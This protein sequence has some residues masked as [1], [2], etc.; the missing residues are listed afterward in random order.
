MR[1]EV[2]VLICGG[3]GCGLA[4]AVMLADLGVDYLL[5]ER[6]PTTAVM[7][8]AHILNVR[9]MEILGQ[10]GLAEEVYRTGAPQERNSTCR[11]YT[12]LGGEEPWD[13]RELFAVDAWGGRSLRPH[14]RRLSAYRHGNV[15]QIL[16]EPLLRREAEARPL[17]EVLFNHELTGFEQDDDGVTAEI[18]DRESGETHSVH[19]GYLI[20][21]DGGKTVGSRLGIEMAGPEPFVE[22]VSVYFRADLSPYLD[23]DDSLIRLFLRP[24]TEGG[25]I[26]TGCVGHGPTKWDRHCEE[27]SVS[28]TLTPEQ[29]QSEYDE[30]DAADAVRERLNLPDL[31]LEV[32]RTS[33]WKIEAVVA[34]RYRAGRVFLAGDA[35]HR[36][37]PMGGLGL[38]TG[39]QDA[40]NLTAKLAAVVH[41]QARPALLESYE[42]ERRPVGRRNVEFSTFAF[43]NHLGVSAGF[44]TMPGAPPSHNRAALEALFSDTADGATRRARLEGYFQTLRMEFQCA[45]I[46]LGFEYS[47]SPAVVPDGSD[48]PRRDPTG[49]EYVPVARPGHRLPHAWLERF[50]RALSTHHLQR[51]GWWL[52]LAGD[53]GGDWCDA[54][55]GLAAELGLDLAAERIGPGAELRDAHDEWKR[56][57][58]HDE[59]GAVLVRPD[60]HVA[61]RAAGAADPAALRQAFNRSLALAPVDPNQTDQ[62]GSD[63]LQQA[64]SGP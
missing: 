10:H 56:V 59:A 1:E 9:T 5:V 32:L 7:P 46:D 37:S 11:W 52:L 19:G 29:R 57:R 45:D 26:R 36:H 33:R 4:A 42:A 40:H 63:E 50:G 44:G 54:A 47:D 49:Y 3:G 22:T 24:T 23:N 13:D 27:W 16:L 28:V 39:I 30:A 20:G 21:A 55:A 35:A 8:K 6:H 12:S 53:D 18:R 43:F 17:G 2:P 15:P 51:P 38:N 58:G 14:Y 25:W 64:I 31:E 48:A 61:F 62:G 60:G 34:E 41:G